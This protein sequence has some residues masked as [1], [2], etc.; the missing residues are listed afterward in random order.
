MIG[1]FIIAA[2]L[3]IALGV[4]YLITP[5]A[6]FTLHRFDRHLQHFSS[7]TTGTPSQRANVVTVVVESGQVMNTSLAPRF[8][9][10]VALTLTTVSIPVQATLPYV[11]QDA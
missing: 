2:A 11:C 9:F 10:A 3:V 6:M 4:A 5:L 7:K 8:A 1:L